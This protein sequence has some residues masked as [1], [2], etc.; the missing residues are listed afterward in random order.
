MGWGIRWRRIEVPQ[1]APLVIPSTVDDQTRY[2]GEGHPARLGLPTRGR[3]QVVQR[4]P[5]VAL[6]HLPS[7]IGS[8]DP[9][10][11]DRSDAWWD[12]ESRSLH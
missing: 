12:A 4:R 11:Q 8:N 6:C 9:S 1:G 7:G 3:T 10:P 5:G 2:E